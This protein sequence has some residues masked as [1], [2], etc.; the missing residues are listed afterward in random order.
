MRKN[1]QSAKL[2]PISAMSP[3]PAD[4][5][6][7]PISSDVDIVKA[8]QAGRKVAEDVGFV[9]TELAL[10]ATAISELARNIV[11]YARS[12]EIAIQPIT[13]SAR[14]GIQIVAQDH[15]PGIRDVEQALQIGFSTAGGLGLG[16]PG[17]RRLMDEFDIQSKLGQGTTVRIAK[18]KD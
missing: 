1:C 13:N 7:I 15:G 11:R 8:R 3:S 2:A 9:F 6:R 18:W 10:I 5:V 16:L 12:G 17:V 4:A 14:R